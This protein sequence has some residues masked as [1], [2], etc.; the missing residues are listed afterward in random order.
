MSS[1]NIKLDG[2][3]QSIEPGTDGF[4]LFADKSV[5]ALRVN[6]EPRDLAHQPSAGDF[7]EPIHISSA[8]GLAILRHST[9]HVLA[10]AV[11][12][13]RPEATLGIGPAIRD[14]FY[15]DFD[16][17]VPFTPEE[18]KPSRSRWSA[19]F[20]AGKDLSVA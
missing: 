19:L 12:T 7:V 20:G 8:D 5:I 15:Y 13:I 16:V 2:V 9:A 1:F 4:K 18:L 17:E 14:G 6:G 11:Q 10:Q 3:N